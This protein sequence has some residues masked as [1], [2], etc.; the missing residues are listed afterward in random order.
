MKRWS[1][2]P[3]VTGCNS[4]RELLSSYI[5]GELSVRERQFVDR[6]IESCQLC[7]EELESLQKTINL[8]QHI[9]AIEPRR[10]FTVSGDVK[11]TWDI[12]LKTLGTATAL[13]A[14]CL[15]VVF[16]GDICHFFDAMPLPSQPWP[17]PPEINKYYWPVRETELG[18]LGVF[19]VL[20][21]VSFWYWYRRVR[22]KSRRSK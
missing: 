12:K 8:V 19:I 9:P 6:H 2:G 10:S 11:R 13:V 4:V 14:V 3:K 1:K 20:A 7:R 5:D 22:K 16:I 18:L 17:Q 15:M 21:V